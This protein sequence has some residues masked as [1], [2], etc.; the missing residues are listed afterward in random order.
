MSDTNVYFA[1]Q[2]PWALK[3]TDPER[4]ATVLYTTEEIIRQVAILI[5]PIMPDS[6]AKLLDILKI[7]A[8]ERGFEQL[9]SGHR[10]ATGTALDKPEGV[11]PRYI[12]DAK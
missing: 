9:G 4:M 12:A 8:G 2:A 3:N 7:P 1:G 6:G 5:Q 10:L 11:F